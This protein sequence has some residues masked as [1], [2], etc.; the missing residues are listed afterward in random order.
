MTQTRPTDRPVILV[1]GA[2]GKQGG[3]TVDALLSA[4]GQP[5]R[6]RALSRDPAS[7]AAKRLAERGVEVV[8]GDQENA[9]SL[10]A[11]VAGAHGVFSIQLSADFAAEN[12]QA[13]N[14]GEAA[15]RAGVAHIVATLA[16]GAGM[17]DSGLERFESK[18]SIA[19]YLKALGIPLTI[20]RPTGF[21]ENFLGS[22]AAILNGTVT[23]ATAP[24]THNWYIAV[25]DIGAFAAAAFA[26]PQTYAGAEIDLAG[27]EMTG[28]ALAQVFSD[29]TGRPVAFQQT[30][31][32]EMVRTFPA[33]RVALNDWYD[34]VGYGFDV[35]ALRS[36]WPSPPLMTLAQWL[37]TPAWTSPG[38]A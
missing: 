7:P 27:D 35:A 10:D 26:A 28:T 24:E 34:R 17:E 22:R 25:A 3:A 18:R 33:E 6:V 9:A 29:A 21:M 14:L 1:T 23:A 11:A 8:K 4:A 19:D 5:W 31:R 2:T 37:R 20:L 30:P 36:R 15:K 13:R 38:T 16:A 32:A 12:R